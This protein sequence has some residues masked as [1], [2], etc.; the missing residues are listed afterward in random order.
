MNEAVSNLHGSHELC[1][2]IVL[3]K[4]FNVKC[5]YTNILYF[6]CVKNCLKSYRILFI[7]Y[8]F[9]NDKTYFQIGYV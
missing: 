4:E 7:N 1:R 3:G 8:F 5:K 2:N 9:W 6:I